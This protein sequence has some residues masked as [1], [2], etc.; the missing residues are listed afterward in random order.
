MEEKKVL[1]SIKD[2]EVKFRV[3]GRILT[4]IR[5][6]SLDLYE[7]ESIAIVGESGSGKSVFTKTFA[8]MLDSNGFISQGSIIFAD[9][10]LAV[11][12][13]SVQNTEADL[14]R[15]TLT[16]RQ[17]KKKAPINVWVSIGIAVVGFYLLCIK[18]NLTIAPSD[19]LVVIAAM[20]FP[21]HI[22]TIDHFSPRC[23]GVRMSMVQFFV[24]AVINLIIALI[25]ESPLDFPLVFD[26]ILPILFLAIGSSGIA[27]TLQIIGQKGVNPAVASIILSLESVFGVIGTALFLGQTLSPREYIGC[28]VVL[29][30]VVLSQISFGKKK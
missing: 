24:A 4:A 27:Y 17:L 21:I 2:L 18:E 22:L 20:I 15:V 12:M 13:P 9:D 11:L 7:N 25:A 23:D 30:A 19:I 10:E 26:N 3:R 14:E 5:G 29:A 6:A 28:A 16:L 8:G 1:L